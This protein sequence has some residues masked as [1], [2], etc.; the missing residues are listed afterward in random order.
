MKGVWSIYSESNLFLFIDWIFAQIVF[1]VTD[2]TDV[3]DRLKEE[4]KTAGL[5]SPLPPQI[6][7][8]HCLGLKVS[9]VG[10]SLY[11]QSFWQ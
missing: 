5:F 6:D 10:W 11:F 4:L 7:S 8:L 9:H 2:V 1:S 3:T